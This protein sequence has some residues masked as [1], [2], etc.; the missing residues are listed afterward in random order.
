VSKTEAKAA[1]E[2]AHNAQ[3]ATTVEARVGIQET[4]RASQ[5][6]QPAKASRIVRA[7]RVVRKHPVKAAVGAAAVAG[8]AGFIIDHRDDDT[9]P[10]EQLLHKGESMFKSGASAVEKAAQ[11]PF[12]VAQGTA[13]I[14]TT[15]AQLLAVGVGVYIVYEIYQFTKPSSNASS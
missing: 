1:S 2:I 3:R 9:N 11:L 6:V 5:L 10:L 14:V 13:A 7:A 8:T 4:T 15:G 12:K